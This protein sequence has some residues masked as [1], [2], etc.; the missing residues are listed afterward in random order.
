MLNASPW[1][2]GCPLGV[3]AELLTHYTK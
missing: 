2:E 3:E 1:A